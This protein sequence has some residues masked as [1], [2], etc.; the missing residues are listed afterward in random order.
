[1]DTQRIPLRAK[2]AVITI[3]MVLT[4]ACPLHAERSIK[5]H[6]PTN[7]YKGWRLGTQ[8]YS[9]N[10]FSFYEAIDKTA[11]LGLNYIEAYPGQRLTNEKDAPKTNP[12]LTPKQR[13][14]I[15]DRLK[16]AGIKLVN[17]GVVG[18]GNDEA[19]AREIFDFAKDMGIET[20]V[21]EPPLDAIP[22]LDKLCQEY[23]IN[24]AIH[25]HPKPS[26]YWNPDTV[27]KACEG[28]SK[29]VGACADTGHWVRSELDPVQCLKKLQ[30]RIISLH[31]KELQDGHDVHW[32][33]AHNRAT[34]LL[35]ELHRQNFKGVFSIEYEYNW[36]NSV[37]DIRKCVEFF[38]AESAK[39]NPTGWTP[40]FDAKLSNADMKPG[41]WK[42]EEEVLT[43]KGGGDIWTK[44]KY[45]DFILDF[46]FKVAKGSNSGAF[47]RTQNHKWLPWVEVQVEDSFGKKMSNHLAGGIFDIHEP[48]ENVV[49][50]PG[51]W[52]RMTILA[53]GP[54]INVVLN[55]VQTLNINLDDWTE[56]HKNPQDGS[57]NKFNIAYKDLPRTGFIGLQDH[58]QEIWFRNVKIR[59]LE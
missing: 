21:S 3:L 26:R 13:Q 42:W 20:I 48:A 16:A 36:A 15:K 57:R 28:R 56:A 45:S 31:F 33:T 47:L 54:K 1:M 2:L 17:F 19:K 49:Y 4:I 52:N 37:P 5:Q 22:M 46:Q 59:T 8:A 51:K 40:L 6:P 11:S 58:G 24:L 9:F 23:K 50:P 39:L 43:R 55:G 12:S 35:A 41:S 38:D 10:R 27:L 18:L 32:G 14:E 44:A 29:Y 30:G 7:P 53:K 25:N 34:P